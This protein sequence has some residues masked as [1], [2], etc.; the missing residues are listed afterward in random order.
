M[1][2]YHKVGVGCVVSPGVWTTKNIWGVGKD[3]SLTRWD[4]SWGAGVGSA[5]QGTENLVVMQG[6]T[7][8]RGK[9]KG[10]GRHPESPTDQAAYPYG[11]LSLPHHLFHLKNKSLSSC[12]I[13]ARLQWEED[14]GALARA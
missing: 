7:Q 1:N 9:T 2:S 14:D 4:W 12:R 3:E 10:L 13:L 5:W 11:P 8:P 6:E